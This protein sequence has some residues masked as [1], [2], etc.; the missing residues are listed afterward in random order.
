MLSF[1]LNFKFLEKLPEGDFSITPSS[2]AV[3]TNIV[4]MPPPSSEVLRGWTKPPSISSSLLKKITEFTSP[5]M[6]KSSLSNNTAGEPPLLQGRLEVP[7]QILS[8][9]EWNSRIDFEIFSQRQR[10][11]NVNVA[12]DFDLLENLALEKGHYKD[13][14]SFRE[15]I[16]PP[17]FIEQKESENGLFKSEFQPSFEKPS[18]YEKLQLDTLFAIFY[19][20]PGT[21]FQYLAAR[22][23]K[24]QSWRFHKKYLTWFQRH[25]EPKVITEDYEQG[26]YIYF[27]YEGSWCQRKKSEFTFEYRFLEDSELV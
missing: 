1:C 22:E 21:F 9:K 10:R 12:G 20:L 13:L 15:V 19:Y 3:A 17:P 8:E 24:R 25:E 7:V 2:P 5:P 18:F 23:L 14:M 26:T 6:E 27:D 11:S 4:Q 16:V